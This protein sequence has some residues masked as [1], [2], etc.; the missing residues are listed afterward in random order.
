MKVSK[1]ILSAALSIL[2]AACGS[3]GSG[4]QGRVEVASQESAV[5]ISETIQEN[6]KVDPTVY[7]EG[8]EPL[9]GDYQPDG[10]LKD[11]AKS[12]E[13]Y[14]IENKSLNFGILV[15]IN[16]YKLMGDVLIQDLKAE[17]GSK[18]FITAVNNMIAECQADEDDT[19]SNE[20]GGHGYSK[21]R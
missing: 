1:S 20:E 14:T 6:A 16:E 10:E 5:S 11:S 7:S 13:D 17:F 21:K 15:A 4:E 18:Q 3:G 19:V 2:L 8:L 9:S 12:P